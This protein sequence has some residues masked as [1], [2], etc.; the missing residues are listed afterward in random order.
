MDHQDPSPATIS[1]PPARHDS[2]TTGAPSGPGDTE[3]EPAD[4]EEPVEAPADG[5]GLRGR[6]S[7]LLSVSQATVL[8]VDGMLLTSTRRCPEGSLTI[9]VEPAERPAVTW[10]NYGCPE[11]SL[12]DVVASADLSRDGGP[13]DVALDA[14]EG[15]QQGVIGVF[16]G[17]G[18]VTLTVDIQLARSG[19]L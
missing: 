13:M 19:D 17:V 9:D 15:S 16:P 7:G 8:V 1:G 5:Y 14:S 4:T 2:G 12:G 3:E 18:E 6:W 10:V 11:L